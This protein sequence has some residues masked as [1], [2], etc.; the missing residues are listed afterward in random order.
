MLQMWGLAR[1]AFALALI[2]LGVLGIVY[3][4]FA[5]QWQ[6]V[7]AWV[8]A[9]QF[10]AY[11]SG[12]VILLAGAGML[13]RRA[14]PLSIRVFVVYALLWLAL[15]LPPLVTAPLIEAHWLGA[16]ELAVIVAA[17]WVLFTAQPRQRR[18]AG[19]LF[20]VALIPIGLSHF[21]YRPETL[22]FVP[23]WLPFRS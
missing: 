15:K 1:L 16:G 22:S 18:I 10:L 7:P 23:A 5:L 13:F 21:F 19:Y 9:R 20:G 8:P 12:V 2:G 17:A 11:A 3:G 14:E 4:D 6:P